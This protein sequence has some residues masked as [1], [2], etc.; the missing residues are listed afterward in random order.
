MVRRNLILA[1]TEEKSKSLITLRVR[2][3]RLPT[4][5]YT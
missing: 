1:R 5:K 3:C 4:R 2:Q